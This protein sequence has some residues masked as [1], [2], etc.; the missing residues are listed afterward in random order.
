MIPAPVPAATPESHG[1]ASA[2]IADTLATLETEGLDPHGFAI[3]RHGTLLASGSWAPWRPEQPALV[4]SVS[5][6]FTSLAVGYLVAEG[7]LTID[8]N[9]SLHLPHPNPTGI[10]VRDL[11]AMNTG[12]SSEQLARLGPP[13]A[14]EGLLTTPPAHA[15][16]THFAYSSPASQVLSDMV[17]HLTGQRL[18]RY[19]RHRLLDPLGIPER[20][21]TPQGRLDQGYSGLHLT[22]EDLLR[23]GIALAAGGKFAGTQVIPPAWVKSLGQV[24]ADNSHHDPASPDFSNGYGFQ[25][26]RSTRG[27]RADGAYGQFCLVLPEHELTI[28]YQGATRNTQR[29]LTVWW[30]LVDSLMDGPLPAN[31]TAV[32]TLT[33]QLEALDSWGPPTAPD[34]EQPLTRPSSRPWRITPTATGWELTLGS[35]CI[36]VGRDEWVHEAHPVP[37]PSGRRRP[38]DERDG[39]LLTA[40]RGTELPD[41]SVEIHV[42]NPSSPH[43]LIVRGGHEA[44]PAWHTVPLWTPLLTDLA[45]PV[46]VVAT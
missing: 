20:W 37:L 43:R 30:R 26:W 44:R 38:G 2:A 7:R 34:P 21:W 15:R 17:T 11:L 25:V 42:A 9:V 8:D 1:L 13:Y 5:K 35:T 41:G 23:L 33:E 27:F 18:S 14:T 31:P 32:A 24:A 16:G 45:V 4:Y 36:A 29:V 19:L 28:A 12:H 22:V 46:N 39:L 3:A 40:A 10:T 6:T